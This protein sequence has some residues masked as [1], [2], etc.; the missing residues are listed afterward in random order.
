MIAWSLLVVAM[1]AAP[2]PIDK[3]GQHPAGVYRLPCGASGDTPL[4]PGVYDGKVSRGEVVQS[5]VSDNPRAMF[6]EGRMVVP[7]GE[8]WRHCRPVVLTPGTW[9]VVTQTTKVRWVNRLSFGTMYQRDTTT[10]VVTRTFTIVVPGDPLKPPPCACEN[11]DE[12]RQLLAEKKAQQKLWSEVAAELAA[13]GNRFPS[14]K[15]QVGD[16]KA[17]YRKKLENAFP[18]KEW[19]QVGGVNEDLEPVAP[20]RGPCDLVSRSTAAH[21]Q[22]HVEEARKTG[23]QDALRIGQRWAEVE[24]RCHAVQVAFLEKEIAALAADLECPGS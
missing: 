17:R 6:G 5:S 13:E 1:L 4:D 24:M 8:A 10:K 11:L 20:S 18:G 14:P 7:A 23:A 21:E 16:A 2:K 22:A 12:L 15:A 19:T 9:F 3:D